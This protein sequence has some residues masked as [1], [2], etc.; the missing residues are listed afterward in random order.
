[1]YILILSAFLPMPS[2]YDDEGRV[3][4]VI[5]AGCY[6][7][8]IH[9]PDDYLNESIMVL[10]CRLIYGR[11]YSSIIGIVGYICVYLLSFCSMDFSINKDSLFGLKYSSL[12][13]NEIFH[14]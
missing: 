4:S 9:S 14:R 7:P 1:M 10:H 11:F 8:R 12:V 3:I 2:T 5:R 6:N 13:F